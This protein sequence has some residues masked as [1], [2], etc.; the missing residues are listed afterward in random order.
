M[1]LEVRIL[2]D[3][4]E[5]EMEAK[6]NTPWQPLQWKCAPSHPIECKREGDNGSYLIY[7]ITV[8]PTVT[9]ALQKGKQINPDQVRIY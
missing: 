1:I 3:S 8:T 5:V 9:L 4:G 2:N 7:C 6:S